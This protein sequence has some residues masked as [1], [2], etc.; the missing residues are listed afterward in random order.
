MCTWSPINYEDLTPMNQPQL[1]TLSG[2]NEAAV[3]VI[4]YFMIHRYLLE[5][6]RLG[7]TVSDVII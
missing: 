3:R 5:I 6:K 7:A 1:I 2:E 4:S